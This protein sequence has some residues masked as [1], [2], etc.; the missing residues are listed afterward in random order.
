MMN[1]QEFIT[2]PT[3]AYLVLVASFVASLSS[4]HCESFPRHY[5]QV[6][7]DTSVQEDPLFT[8]TGIQSRSHCLSVCTRRS[9]GFCLGFVYNK[10]QQRCLAFASRLEPLTQLPEV[11]SVG[12][13]ATAE[14][15]KPD[16]P[17][18]TVTYTSLEVKSVAYYSCLEDFMFVGLS[19]SRMCNSSGLWDG[20]DGSCEP[21]AFYNVSSPFVAPIPG[22]V[23]P[24][25]TFE[26]LGTPLDESRMTIDL[27][28]KSGDVAFECDVRFDYSRFAYTV[29]RTTFSQ[30]RWGPKDIDQPHFPFAIGR[31]FNV[32]MQVTTSGF[33]DTVQVQHGSMCLGCGRQTYFDL[34]AWSQWSRCPCHD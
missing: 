24:G 6:F 25:W 18:G 12:F 16:I 8:E 5:F 33:D 2:G 15:E 19:Q 7:T 13:E 29:L 4:Q 30:N 20:A 3:C 32:T 34:G 22:T 17:N 10:D 26:F 14:C 28:H 21:A 23:G 11:G 9:G 1:V 27:M 31:P